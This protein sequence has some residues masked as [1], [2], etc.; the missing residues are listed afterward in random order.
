MEDCT[1]YSI[2][3]TSVI[4]GISTKTLRYYDSIKLVIPEIR[5][6]KNNYRYYSNDQVI[7]LLAVQRLRLIGCS[8]RMLRTLI[9]ENSLESLCDQI[10][11]RI[12]ELKE[13]IDERT[14]TI[15]ENTVFLNQLRTQLDIHS[16]LSN[17]GGSILDNIHVEVIKP[18]LIFFE[19]RVIPNY[20]VCSTSLNFRLELRSKCQEKGLSLTGPEITTYYTSPLG[21]FVVHDCKIRIGIVVDKNPG[22][23]QIQ[24]FGGFTAVTA[25]HIGSYDTMVNTHMMMLRWINQN[26]YE[27]CGNISEEFTMSPIDILEQK[28]QIIKVIMPVRRV[29]K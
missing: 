18:S 20:D 25:I 1:R 10:E 27:L 26:Q 24:E 19:E 16:A 14:R 22:C 15:N 13:E 7:R 12:Q 21:Q 2:G 23:S 28:N 3:E 29:P 17:Q 5:D 4:T 9:Q 8:Q 11:L 6:P